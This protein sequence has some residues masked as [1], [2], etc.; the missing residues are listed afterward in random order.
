VSCLGGGISAAVCPAATSKPRNTLAPQHTAHT[1]PHLVHITLT[2]AVGAEPES[3]QLAAQLLRH[4]GRT[5]H[6]VL[7]DAVAV[8]PERG[9]LTLVVGGGEDAWMVCTARRVWEV[10]AFQATGTHSHEPPPPHTH[11]RTICGSAR[12][13]ATLDAR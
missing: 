8:G 11:T 4:L 10:Q 1:N 6:A 13:P 12:A 9:G 3:L 7:V 5:Q 2:A